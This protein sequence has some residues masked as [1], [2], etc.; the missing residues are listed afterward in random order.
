[1]K[2]TAVKS[3]TETVG[4]AVSGNPNTTVDGHQARTSTGIDGGS[5]WRTLGC[6]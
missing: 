2:I 6:H 5:G 1:M 3:D 4:G